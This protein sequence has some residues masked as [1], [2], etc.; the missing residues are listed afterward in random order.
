M[1]TYFSNPIY[2]SDLAVQY[3]SRYTNNNNMSNNLLIILIK[4]HFN[5]TQ[6]RNICEKI[7]TQ[8]QFAV[9]ISDVES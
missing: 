2:E 1:Q 5:F 4:T 9:I 8:D 7:K 3:I 6:Y